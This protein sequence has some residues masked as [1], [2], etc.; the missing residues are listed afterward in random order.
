[1]TSNVPKHNS[2]GYLYKTLFVVL[3]S[4]VSLAMW[5]TLSSILSQVLSYLDSTAVI[6]Y[7]MARTLSSDAIMYLMFLKF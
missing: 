6:T 1:M 5:A 2:T 3:C 4:S 7:L